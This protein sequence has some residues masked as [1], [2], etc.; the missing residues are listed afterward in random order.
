MTQEGTNGEINI[1]V[2]GPAWGMQM[3]FLSGDGNVLT[4]NAD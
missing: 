3:T 2:R 1:A 4:K